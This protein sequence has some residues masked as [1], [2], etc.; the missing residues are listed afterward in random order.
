MFK[1]KQNGSVETGCII[2]YST[3]LQ[4]DY[5]LALDGGLAKGQLEEALTEKLK[6]VG[7]LKLLKAIESL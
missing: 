1:E 3:N 4:L 2:K 5:N 6:T 7:F